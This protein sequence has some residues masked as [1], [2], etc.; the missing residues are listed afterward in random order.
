MELSRRAI[1]F[2]RRLS[3]PSWYEYVGAGGPPATDEDA[4]LL[5]W[6]IIVPTKTD[7]EDAA[8]HVIAAGY[9]AKP[10]NGEWILTDP[11]GTSLRLVPEKK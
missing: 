2:R 4:R 8:R 9:E 7:A 1:P 10:E 3:S 6:E 11:W 5:E